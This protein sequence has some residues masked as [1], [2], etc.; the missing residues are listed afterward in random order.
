MRIYLDNNGTTEI[1]PRVAEAVREELAQGPANPSS[2]H[3]FGQEA[4]KRQMEAREKIGS[5]FG[6]KPQEVI[7][8][9]GGTESLNM[10]LRGVKVKHVISSDIEHSAVYNTLNSLGCTVTFLTTG[11]RGAVKP[12]EVEAN[13]RPETGLIVFGAANSETGVKNEIVAIAEIAEKNGI[14]FLVDG[15]ALLGKEPFFIPSGVSAI[16]FSGHKFHAPKGIGLVLVRSSFKIQPLITGGDQEYSR[17]AGTENLPGIIGIAKAL[18]ILEEEIA[19]ASVRMRQLRDE[20]EE[21]LISALPDVYLNGE[22]ERTTNTSNLSFLGVDGETL[23]MHLDRAG[24]AASHGSACSS[25]ALE[26]SRVLINM[27]LGRDRARSALR[28]SINRWTTR[29]ELEKAAA[30]LISL[31]RRLRTV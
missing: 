1:D 16:A 14:P 22:G 4:R 8:T 10:I 9:S 26:P 7:F 23:L 15:V 25:G 12:E 19:E 31:V 18:D 11:S 27:G 21:K 17:R 20:F 24:I 13:I 5:F 2:T 30:I 6:F 29:E 3:Y 28:F